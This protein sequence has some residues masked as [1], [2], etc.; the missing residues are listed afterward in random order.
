M[1]KIISEQRISTFLFW[2]FTALLHAHAFPR[3]KSVPSRI[4]RRFLRRQS[5]AVPALAGILG[6]LRQ[7]IPVEFVYWNRLLRHPRWDLLWLVCQL[8][9]KWGTFNLRIQSGQ[10]SWKR[11]RLVLGRSGVQILP[12]PI[13]FSIGER[14]RERFYAVSHKIWLRRIEFEVMIWYIESTHCRLDIAQK[15]ILPDEGL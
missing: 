1:Q 2:L 13:A 5:F 9:L 3:P 11:V 7:H 6:R 8:H 12:S 4:Y 14:L 15:C 10:L